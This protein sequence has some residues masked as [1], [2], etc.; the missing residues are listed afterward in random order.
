MSGDFDVVAA[1]ADQFNAAML[2]QGFQRED[3]GGRLLRGFYH[4]DH[5]RYGF[6]MVSG[7]LFD[8]R[9]DRGRLVRLVIGE[10][11]AAVALPSVED[12]IADRLGQHA[13]GGRSDASRLLQAKAL[14]ALATGIDDDYLRRRIVEE[15]GDPGLILEDRSDADDQA[16]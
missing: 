3:R 6:E 5:P 9:A 15:G 7:A 10:G 1:D 13:A 11:G 4:P 14:F 8:G 16:D 2:A 12:M